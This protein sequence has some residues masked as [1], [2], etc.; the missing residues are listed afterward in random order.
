MTRRIRTFAAAVAMAALVLG[1]AAPAL[2]GPFQ[3]ED[4]RQA[5][6]VPILFDIFVLRPL[7]LVLT[8]AGAVLY[9][10]PVAPIMAITRP[11]D[12][13]KP[14]DPLVVTPARFTFA[15]PLGEH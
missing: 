9:A 4:D 10:V 14:L 8:A 1:H 12:I 11:T 3:G 6:S 7:G 13:A 15:D 2:A 5:N